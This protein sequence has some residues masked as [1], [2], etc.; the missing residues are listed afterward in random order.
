MESTNVLVD[1]AKPTGVTPRL[2]IVEHNPIPESFA[3]RAP[4]D[5]G[6]AGPYGQQICC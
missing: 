5:A 2:F 4:V 6:Q 1:E 3:R